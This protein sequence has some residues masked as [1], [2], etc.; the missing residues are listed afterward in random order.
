MQMYIKIQFYN[1]IVQRNTQFKKFG[2]I[3]NHAK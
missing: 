3:I 1:P 2:L